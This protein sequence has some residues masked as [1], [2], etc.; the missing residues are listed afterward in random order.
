M[1]K[2]LFVALSLLMV[3]ALFVTGCG[4]S[5]EPAGDQPAEQVTDPIVWEAA[6]GW[7]P[8]DIMR[9]VFDIF[10]EVLEEKTEG[11]LIINVSGPET[12]PSPDQIKLLADGTLD[13]IGTTPAFY[14]QDLPEGTAI[15]YTWGTKEERE[16]AGLFE[17]IDQTHREKYN[18]TL[19]TECPAGTMHIFMKDPI[20]SVDDLRGKRLRSPAAYM[21]A[22]E[23]LG[24]TS[25]FMS[26][27]DTIDSLQQ[28]VIDGAISSTATYDSWNYYEVA[29]YN[30]YPSFAFVLSVIFANVDS[31]EALPEHLQVALYE[32]V[33]EAA[34]LFE[35]FAVDQITHLFDTADEKG[36]V[37]ITFEGTEAQE[38][39]DIF[40]DK[41][42]EVA[43]RP[44]S[45]DE[46]ADRIIEIH[47]K[48]NAP[49][50]GRFVGPY[51]PVN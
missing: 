45:G 43:V 4:G 18:A 26:D 19:I 13:L 30:I 40:F 21:P 24:A 44:N 7:V 9:D 46:M 39:Y 36:V 6:S 29:P 15:A 2:V 38:F 27:A 17:L 12:F 14:L 35:Q 28:G 41:Y 8:G 42:I 51:S 25:M 11:Q 47:E 10:I 48:L 49:P 20:D 1:K 5:T 31:V 32:A 37:D 3:M 50:Q 34:P 16:A 33:E 22:L 23:A